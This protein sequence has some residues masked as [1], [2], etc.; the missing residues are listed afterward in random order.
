M[1][2]RLEFVGVCGTFVVPY[3]SKKWLSYAVVGMWDLW[4]AETHIYIERDGYT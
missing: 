3:A 2:N 1:T 4:E